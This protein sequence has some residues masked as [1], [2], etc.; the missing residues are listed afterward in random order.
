MNGGL[1]LIIMVMMFSIT[2]YSFFGDSCKYFAAENKKFAHEIINQ[3]LFLISYCDI[4]KN[5]SDIN[6]QNGYIPRS[7]F[8]PDIFQTNNSF[9]SKYLLSCYINN[10]IYTFYYSHKTSGNDLPLINLA[11]IFSYVKEFTENRFFLITPSSNLYSS[12][13]NNLCSFNEKIIN[14]KNIPFFI[15]NYNN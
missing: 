15:V 8:M 13:P 3:Q 6:H 10:H 5:C 11:Q 9:S 4:K 14:K 2:Q 12:I 1:Y 7:Y